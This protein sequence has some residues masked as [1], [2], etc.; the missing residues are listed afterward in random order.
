MYARDSF[1]DLSLAGQCGLVALSLLLSIA[2]L[3][4]ARLLL[5]TGAIWVRLLGAFS[6]YWL[7]VWLSPQVY[8]E[9]YRLLIPSLPAQWVIWPPRTPA[10]AL[11]LLALQGPH[12]LSAHGQALLGWS[13]LAAPFVRVSRK[14]RA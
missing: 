9:Y 10:E 3:L 1:F 11:A 4:V 6:L 7:F 14:R 13:L 8:Y 2:F 12:S 5:R